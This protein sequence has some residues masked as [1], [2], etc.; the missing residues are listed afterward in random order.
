M[1]ESMTRVF[2]IA[3]VLSLLLTC[4]S[5]AAPSDRTSHEE[6][7]RLLI[8]AMG[9][10][11]TAEAGA[12][13]MMGM[14]LD[15]PELAPY[16]DVFRSWYRKIFAAGDFEGE[17]AQIYMKHFTEPELK[18]LRA[19]YQSPIGQKMLAELPA[20]MKEGADLGMARAKEHEAELIEMLNTAKA[21]REKSD[22]EKKQ[23]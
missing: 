9:G 5:Y 6:A 19:L 13:A 21:Q 15:N 7:A 11:A 20:V 10:V 14:I 2:R 18:E 3:A 22:T 16:E 4:S 23:D 8:R 1:E 17:M 12:D